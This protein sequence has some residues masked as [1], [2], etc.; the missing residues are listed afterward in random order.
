MSAAVGSATRS[1]PGTTPLATCQVR[2]SQESGA[3]GSVLEE[4]EGDPLANRWAEAGRRCRGE[5]GA[6]ETRRKDRHPGETASP[7]EQRHHWFWT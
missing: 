4:P 2:L 5:I 3:E 7:K 6:S 1:R